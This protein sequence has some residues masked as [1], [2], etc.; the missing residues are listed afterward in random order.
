VAPF[1]GAG[2][3]FAYFQANQE[4]APSFNGSGFGGYGEVG[5]GFMRASRVGAVVNLRADVPMFSLQQSMN[6]YTGL[7][8]YTT[9]SSSVYVVPV[10]LNVGLAFQ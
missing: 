6:D 5:V 10:S 8:G 1:I 7:G 4:N 3:M 9:A 2:L